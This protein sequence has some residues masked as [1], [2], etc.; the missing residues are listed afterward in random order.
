MHSTQPSSSS[1]TWSNPYRHH[2][3]TGRYELPGAYWVCERPEQP[4]NNNTL[5]CDNCIDCLRIARVLY[6]SG[7]LLPQQPLDEWDTNG[8]MTVCTVEDWMTERWQTMYDT[9]LAGEVNY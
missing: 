7:L 6:E 2:D 4:P 8:T 3:V 9:L 1:T 5:Y